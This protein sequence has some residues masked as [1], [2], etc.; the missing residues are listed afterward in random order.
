MGNERQKEKK[1]IGSECNEQRLLKPASKLGKKIA[2]RKQVRSKQ[3]R[4]QQANRP[5]EDNHIP[6]KI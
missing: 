4:S 2:S 1:L 5:I 6:T 3:G